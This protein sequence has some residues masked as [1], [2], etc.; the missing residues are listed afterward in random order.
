MSKKCD[1]CDRFVEDDITRFCEVCW[2]VFQLGRKS[3]IDY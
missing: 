1:N 3:V 2:R